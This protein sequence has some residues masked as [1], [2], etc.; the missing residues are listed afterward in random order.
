ME[1][2]ELITFGKVQ[3]TVWNS[4]NYCCDHTIF[5]NR[6]HVIFSGETSPRALHSQSC[7]VLHLTLRKQLLVVKVSC[8]CDPLYS[9]SLCISSINSGMRESSLIVASSHCQIL[10]CALDKSHSN[11]YSEN[12]ILKSRANGFKS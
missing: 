12:P 2:P 9:K 3:N 10:T 11:N 1:I 4:D 7:P 6:K 8:R 5:M